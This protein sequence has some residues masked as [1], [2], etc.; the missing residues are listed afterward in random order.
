VTGSTGISPFIAVKRDTL[1]PGQNIGISFETRYGRA[2]R[3]PYAGTAIGNIVGAKHQRAREG[4]RGAG[5]KEEFIV[6][7]HNPPRYTVICYTEEKRDEREDEEKL[8][9]RARSKPRSGED[10]TRTRVT[11]ITRENKIDRKKMWKMTR[12]IWKNEADASS[13]S[14]RLSFTTR[15]LSITRSRSLRG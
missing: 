5:K 10:D 7:R 11:R 3:L 4:W 9:P 14:F 6:F 15:L 8:K 12:L 1:R 13:V 2:A